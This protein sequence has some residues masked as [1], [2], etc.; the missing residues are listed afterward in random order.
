MVNIAF[1][2]IMSLQGRRS[3]QSPLS[4]A[5]QACKDQT[6]QDGFEL[7]FINNFIGRYRAS[8]KKEQL[9]IGKDYLT[10]F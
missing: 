5:I 10:Q 7:K 4:K 6:D 2:Q 8:N 3:R 1:S 9:E